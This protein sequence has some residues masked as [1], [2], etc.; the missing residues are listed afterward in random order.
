MRLAYCQTGPILLTVAPIGTLVLVFGMLT[1]AILAVQAQ[2]HG[3]KQ[4]QYA[5][6]RCT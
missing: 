3:L 6:V 5:A 2:V 4:I 1:S